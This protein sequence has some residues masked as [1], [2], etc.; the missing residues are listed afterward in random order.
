MSQ[1]PTVIAPPPGWVSHPQAAGYYYNPQNP[2]QMVVVVQPPAGVAPVAAPSAGAGNYV[3]AQVAP[4]YGEVDPS[5]VTQ[6]M[7][8]NPLGGGKD[9]LRFKFPD[10]RET[11]GAEVSVRTRILPPWSQDARGPCVSGAYHRIPSRFDPKY[12]ENWKGQHIFP[13]CYSAHKSLGIGDC[14]ICEAL[15]ECSISGDEKAGAFAKDG[16]SRE[17]HHW[18]VLNLDD[19]AQ[20][21]K[22]YV[23][24]GEPVKDAQGH[25]LW[26]VQPAL[27][28]APATLQR[29]LSYLFKV[30]GQIANPDRGVNVTL[31]KRRTNKGEPPKNVEYDAIGDM[32][33]AT[34]LD[35]QLRSVLG[36]LV[37]LRKECTRLRPR[38][39][40]EAI[41]EKIR[42][43]YKLRSSRVSAFSPEV[44]NLQQ[45]VPHP[46][47]PA[48]EMNPMTGAIRP[49]APPAVPVAAQPP[50][51]VWSPPTV[52]Q[53]VA[54]P[55]P[56]PLPVAVP[57]PVSMPAYVATSAP[58]PVT[59][60]VPNYVPP[61]A[62]PAMALPPPQAPGLANG[63]VVVPQPFAPV[64]VVAQPLPG[65]P[66]IPDLAQISAPLA[67]PPPPVPSGAPGAPM[68][69]ADL[70]A[71]LSS[72]KGNDGVPF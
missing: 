60:P 65:L 40:M 41:A 30:N 22:Q 2:S 15:T 24:D 20:H 4:T 57:N 1:Y 69:P 26:I 44:P 38:E 16:K 42:E 51:P 13:E 49:A 70:E 7:A 43:Y 28:S 55:L 10:L 32:S 58:A 63:A 12:N 64:G 36:N 52:A 72:A 48:Y 11:E 37:D 18:Q 21:F 47:N 33:G 67:A 61:V 23:R 29:K 27:L 66:A 19:P 25:E 5:F 31:I 9:V 59:V 62:V 46:S 45:W 50:P 6:E 56:P 35:P 68:S 8:K 34:P 39:D 14:P 53:P 17:T 71:L 3:M 54:P